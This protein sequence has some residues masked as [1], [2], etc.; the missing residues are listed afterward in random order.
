MATATI[1]LASGLSLV[2]ATPAI[3]ANEKTLTTASKVKG[4]TVNLGTPSPFG[5]NPMGSVDLSPSQAADTSNSGNFVTEFIPTDPQASVVVAL[6][7]NA[8][9]GMGNPS[10]FPGSYTYNG[11]GA[12][13]NNQLFV[14][15]VTQADNMSYQYYE[16]DIQ[17]VSSDATLSFSNSRLKSVTPG[18]A[19]AYDDI[20]QL[21]T[22]SNRT[23]ITLSS[24]QASSTFG[25]QMTYFSGAGMNAAATAKKFASSV[26]SLDSSAFT[27]ATTVTSSTAITDGDYIVIRVIAED[28]TTTK[29]YGYSVTVSSSGGGG[30]GSSSPSI[31]SS[32]LL[33]SSSTIKGVAFTKGTR[34][35]SSTD[36]NGSGSSFKGSVTLTSEQASGTGV[37]S[38]VASGG[39]TVTW[40]YVSP[41]INSWSNSDI[42][43]TANLQGVT[44]TNGRLFEIKVSGS[45]CTD[46]YRLSIIVG[47]GSNSS[48]SQSAQQAAAVA[49]ET[50]ALLAAAIAKAKVVLTTQFSAN[51]PAT[52]DQFLDAG[53]GVRN[54]NVAVKVSAAILKLSVADRENSQKVNDII[55]LENFID[56]VAVTDTRS[57]VKSTELVSR[58]LLSADSNY[59]HSVI[60]GL[61][62][63]PNGSLDSLEKIAAAVKE[64]IEKAEAPKRRLVE[65]KARIAARKR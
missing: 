56:R 57:S 54:S 34:Q 20:A 15:K 62:S 4:V 47:S 6:Y 63:Y 11:T 32:E 53:Y 55:N 44:L 16:I 26:S 48:S 24:T 45:G 13:S 42:N 31:C 30:G 28:A 38:L 64:Q 43:T 10:N 22:S 14:I 3:A 23:S 29:Y 21:A 8:D 51:K 5:G 40:L 65:I 33:S 12:V 58:G 27:S 17:I 46:Y 36:F 52:M 59:K 60:Q 1:F 39:A 50:A 19:T 41:S 61:A 18:S 37:T 2:G 35:A 25:D 9:F 49:A 7:P